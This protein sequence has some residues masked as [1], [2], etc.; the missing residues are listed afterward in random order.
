MRTVWNFTAMKTTFVNDTAQSTTTSGIA[1]HDIARFKI[2]PKAHCGSS[3]GKLLGYDVEYRESHEPLYVY[4]KGGPDR[5][6]KNHE[7][8]WEA[9]ALGCY[10]LRK[11]QYSTFDD[12]S[13]ARNA[14]WTAMYVTEGD[15]SKYFEVP[16][17]YVERS[18]SEVDAEIARRHP[19]LPTDPNSWANWDAVYRR[20]QYLLEHPDQE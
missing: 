5:V 16:A 3:A 4:V 13:V 20:G 17:N 15:V 1:H 12:G 6:I 19:D 11:D 14:I 8:F 2:V 7:Q 10:A 18:P 9:P